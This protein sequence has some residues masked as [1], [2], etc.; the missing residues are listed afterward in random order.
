MKKVISL[1]IITFIIFSSFSL[2]SCGENDIPAM[3]SNDKYRNFYQ[4]WIGSFCDSDNDETGDLKGIISKLDYLNDGDPNSGIDLGIDGIWLSPMMPS[5]SYHKYDVED[6][7]NIDPE[8]GTMADFQKLI[9]ES[10]NRGINVIIDLVLNHSSTKHPFF[11]KACEELK[12]GKED[13]YA[14]YYNF[15]KK[16][17]IVYKH[18]VTGTSYYYQGD[19]SPEMPDWNLSFEGTR[20]YFDEVT[21]FWLEKG[22]SGFRLDAVKYFKDDHTDA[23]EFLKWFIDTCKKYKEDTYIV[24]EDWDD[25][26]QVYEIYDTGVDSLFNF[27][28]AGAEGEFVKAARSGLVQD[29]VGKLSKYERNISEH[30]KNA[31][32][33][34]FL[35]NHDMVRVANMLDVD[36]NKFAACVYILS[37]GNSFTYNGEEIGIEAPNTTNDAAYRTAMIWDNENLPDVFSPG[38]GEAEANPLGGVKQQ[39]LDEDSL[40]NTYKKLYK[41]RLQ[42]PEIARGRI[43]KVIKFSD[44]HTA[45]YIESYKDSKIVIAYNGSDEKKDLDIKEAGNNFELRAQIVVTPLDQ[46]PS[47][48]KVTLSGTTINMPGKSV[49]VI[50]IK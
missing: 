20:E 46:K 5:H 8:F 30:N 31:I 45:A 27:K 39:L 25:A 4:I 15:S 12:Q 1:I 41:I 50:K 3:K 24:G 19:F 38:I 23:K 6:Y 7:M 9:S 32:N 28:M 43:E 36:E 33:A 16:S 48:E 14:R 21:K 18:N 34:N 26:T 13:G 17:D 22:V 2:I 44:I 47:G 29:M 49:A 35:T 11:L 40:L 10:N 42:N 37:P